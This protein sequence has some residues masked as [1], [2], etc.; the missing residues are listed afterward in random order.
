M[1]RKL[2][3]SGSEFE[4]KIGYSRAVVD[5][6]FVFVSGTTGYNY[7]SMSI[8]SDIAEQTEQCFVNIESVLKQAGSSINDIVRVTYVLPNRQDFESCWPVLNKWLGNVRPA[9]MMFEARLLKDEMKIEVE[10]TAKK[11]A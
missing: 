11:N 1:T 2:I 8:S 7:E 6:D 5:G 4:N 9:A 3:S 10:V